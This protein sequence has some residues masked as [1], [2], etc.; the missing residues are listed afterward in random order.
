MAEYR[1]YLGDKFQLVERAREDIYFRKLDQELIEKMRQ[2]AEQEAEKTEPIESPA[3]GFSSILV[4]V[5]FSPYA[6]R[7][8]E[9]AAD[10]AEHFGSQLTVLHVIHPD[11]GTMAVAKHLK[12]TSSGDEPSGETDNVIDAMIDQQRDQGYA[13]LEAF[14]PP[15]LAQ[16]PIELRVVF[17]RPFERI[18]ETAVQSA[19]D[20]IIMGTHG[21]T[22]IARVALGSVT[23]RV[24]RLAPCPVL[25]VKAPTDESD[26]WLKEF[27]ETF[28][29]IQTES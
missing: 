29:G 9:K 11:A 26:S 23:E 1:D 14:L 10:M 6:M 22:G 25:T 15:R 2:Q 13:A 8:L 12:T 4:P 5:D 28:L 17:G 21:R 20:L 27:Y 18:I 3:K 16:Y 24:V 19:S 7:A